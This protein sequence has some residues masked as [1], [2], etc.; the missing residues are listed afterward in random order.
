VRPI[1]VIGGVAMKVVYGE[2]ALVEV[3]REA[4][5]AVPGQKVMVDQFLAGREF[6]CDAVCDGEDVLIPGIFE[7]IDPSGI[8]SGD[9]IAVFPIYSIT[10]EQQGQVLDFV[11]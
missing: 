4:F 5:E 8:H 1:F 3:L 7:H 2:Q 9:S 11:K 6:E 10:K